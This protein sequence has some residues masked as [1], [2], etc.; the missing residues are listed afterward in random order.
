MKSVLDKRRE[1]LKVSDGQCLVVD[2]NLDYFKSL[3]R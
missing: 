2:P 3:Y 1:R